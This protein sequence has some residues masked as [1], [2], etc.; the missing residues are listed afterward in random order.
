MKNLFVLI[1]VVLSPLF[2]ISQTSP[3][4]WQICF[5]GS[6]TEDARSIYQTSD[7]GYVVAGTSDSYD[8][9][10]SDCVSSSPDYLYYIT[11]LNSL[12]AIVWHKCFDGYPPVDIIGNH[13]V[14][15][16]ED[17]E[18]NLIVAGI[19]WSNE[20][21]QS[22]DYKTLDAYVFKLNSSGDMIWEKFL[23]GSETDQAF[24]VINSGDG[25]YVVA[26]KTQSNDGDVSGLHSVSRNDAWIVK[27]SNDGDILWQNCIGGSSGDLVNSIIRTS[28]GGFIFCGSTGSNDWDVLGNHGGADAWV[29]KLNNSGDIQW[30]NCYGGSRDEEANSIFQTSDGGYIFTGTTDSH[31][32]DV[33]GIVGLT[34]AWVVKINNSGDIQ[35]QKCLGGTN[36]EYGRSIIQNSAGAYILAAETWSNN[37]DVSYNHG[38]ETLYGYCKSDVWIVVLNNDGNI[39]WEHSYGGTGN[40][41]PF[42]I[43]NS[44]DG[45]SVFVGYTMSTN[46]DVVGY[47]NNGDAWIVSLPSSIGFSKPFNLSSDISISPNPSNGFISIS[48]S[49]LQNVNEIKI[50]DISGRQVYYKKF[51]NI[52]REINL[53]LSFLQPSSYYIYLSTNESIYTSK[54]CIIH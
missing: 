34:D 31:D 40:D 41:Y 12:G 23:G 18:G 28:D 30:Q 13:P 33:N 49:T 15:I 5:G 2:C 4:D 27:L 29:V 42:S 8:G 36:Y 37:H 19:K 17:P 53:D 35:W 48:L 32:F 54:F 11:K 22:P 26:C 20:H 10:L 52:L 24:S 46:Y 7:G 16:I 47:H 6:G 14:S 21:S 50:F 9:D 25:G 44:S 43:I 45:G 51:G 39:V 3:I 38:C 1:I